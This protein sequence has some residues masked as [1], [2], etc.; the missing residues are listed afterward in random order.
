MNQLE[1][2]KEMYTNSQWYISGIKE[3]YPRLSKIVLRVIELRLGH[4]YRDGYMKGY[5]EGK[6]IK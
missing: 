6:G 1:L 4:A 3:K 2:K 5:L